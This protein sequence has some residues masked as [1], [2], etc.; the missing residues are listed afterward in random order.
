ME[1]ISQ[2]EQEI[3]VSEDWPSQLRKMQLHDYNSVWDVSPSGL[4]FTCLFNCKRLNRAFSTVSKMEGSIPE[5]RIAIE[6]RLLDQEHEVHGVWTYQ[7]IEL[8]R[9]AFRY[10]E[11]SHRGIHIRTNPLNGRVSVCLCL[12]ASRSMLA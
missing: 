11:R 4:T 9:F 12:A 7:R 8:T 6:C 3:G 10:N 5:E 2:A 1:W